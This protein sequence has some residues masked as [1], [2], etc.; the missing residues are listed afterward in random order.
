VGLGIYTEDSRAERHAAVSHSLPVTHAVVT[1]FLLR[2]I[3]ESR[4]NVLV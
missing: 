2:H 3:E 1:E 4:R